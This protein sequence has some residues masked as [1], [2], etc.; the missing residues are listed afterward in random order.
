MNFLFHHIIARL[1]EEFVTVIQSL[2]DSS[3]TFGFHYIRV[4]SLTLAS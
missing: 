4:F 1:I 3:G 2:C